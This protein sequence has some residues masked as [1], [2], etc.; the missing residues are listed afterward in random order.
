MFN[1]WS[2]LDI[3]RKYSMEMLSNVPISGESEELG[4]H[5]GQLNIGQKKWWT[6]VSTVLE[7]LKIVE[8]DI[9]TRAP[10]DEKN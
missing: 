2:C 5:H 3:A 10:V 4:K 8:L 7:L 9:L 1:I 6:E